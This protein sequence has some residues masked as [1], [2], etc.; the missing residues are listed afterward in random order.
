[1]DTH[2]PPPIVVIIITLFS[3]FQHGAMDVGYNVVRIRN[4]VVSTGNNVLGV[5]HAVFN[6]GICYLCVYREFS[7]GADVQESA[8]PVR[9]S[10]NAH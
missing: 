2:G 4:D 6:T 9:K 1:V 7:L 8:G 3:I 5:H 10:Q